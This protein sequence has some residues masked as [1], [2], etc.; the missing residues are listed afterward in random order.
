VTI[1]PDQNRCKELIKDL[2]MN[3]VTR[4]IKNQANG[5][6]ERERGKKE[7]TRGK[8]RKKNSI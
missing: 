3:E 8:G 1:C 5:H 4:E 2:V 7:N 6:I